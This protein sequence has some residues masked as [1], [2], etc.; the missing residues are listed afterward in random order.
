M[1]PRTDHPHGRE[2][3]GFLMAKLT[4]AEARA[5]EKAQQ[6]LDRPGALDETELEYVLTHWQESARHVNSSAG[7]YFTP[8]DLAS[9]LTLEIGEPASVVDLCAGIG[10]FSLGV[11]MQRRL[12]ATRLEH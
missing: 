3:R 8:H 1:K 11:E 12:T 10:T 6:L 4:K 2:G 5:H 7:A 9:D